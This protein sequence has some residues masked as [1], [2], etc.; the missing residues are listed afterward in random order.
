MPNAFTKQAT[1]SP[2]ANARPAIASAK[3]RFIVGHDS[4]SFCSKAWKMSH[5]LTNPLSGGSPAMAM[6]PTRKHVAV[7]GCRLMRPPSNSMSR[8]PV[9][10]STPPAAMNSRLLKAA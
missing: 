3:T 1:A 10:C 5:S 8:V 4:R 7:H 6:A 9:P 2:A